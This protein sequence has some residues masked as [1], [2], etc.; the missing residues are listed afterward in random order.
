MQQ[1]RVKRGN[2]HRAPKQRKRREQQ[3]PVSLGSSRAP[4]APATV[5]QP[6]HKA[7]RE[8]AR[9]SLHAHDPITGNEDALYTLFY[10]Y[11]RGYTMYS[12]EQGRCCIHGKQGGGCLRIEGL[13]VCFPDIE[14]AKLLIKHLQAEGCTPSEGMDRAVPKSAYVCLHRECVAPQRYEQRP[15]YSL[16]GA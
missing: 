16:A 1:Q 10:E 15:R 8:R 12:T 2:P 14:Q 6:P 3:V 13:Y 7:P 9:L 11:Y 4:H 5:G